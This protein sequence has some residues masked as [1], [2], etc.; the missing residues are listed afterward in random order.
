MVAIE[1]T[2]R[3]D[4]ATKF[5]KMTEDYVKDEIRLQKRGAMVHDTVTHLFNLHR[6]VD[7]D[8]AKLLAR[9]DRLT[10]S[11]ASLKQELADV[12]SQLDN[13]RS[14]NGALATAAQDTLDNQLVALKAIIA[15]A[16]PQQPRQPRKPAQEQQRSFDSEGLCEWEHCSYARAGVPRRLVNMEITREHGKFVP[17]KVCAGHQ[18]CEGLMKADYNGRR[19][20]SKGKKPVDART[21]TESAQ[22]EAALEA[23]VTS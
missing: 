5:E 4:A 10:A 22:N 9:V 19:V 15:K 17:I 16:V 7:T 8:A 21:E 12:R 2:M 3:G 18:Q 1:V 14:R 23:A 6:D 20:S 13:E 11:E